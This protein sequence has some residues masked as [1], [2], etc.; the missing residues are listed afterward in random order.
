MR[1]VSIVFAMLAMLLLNFGG[2]GFAEGEKCSDGFAAPTCPDATMFCDSEVGRCIG[3]AVSGVCTKRP[4]VCTQ[5][6][7]YVCGCD[8]TTYRNDCE[9][10]RAGVP[11]KNEGKC[12]E[13]S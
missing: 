7:S 11:K 3:V 12:A 1:T 10:K 6:I 4:E 8:G 2:T 9:R 13:E 5:E